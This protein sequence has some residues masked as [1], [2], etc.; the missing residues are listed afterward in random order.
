M[1]ADA[2]SGQLEHGGVEFGPFSLE[3]ALVLDPHLSS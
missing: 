2:G 1:T 3:Y